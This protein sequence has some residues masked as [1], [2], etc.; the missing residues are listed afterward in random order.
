MSLS[1]KKEPEFV[2]AITATDLET[3]V[4]YADEDGQVYVLAMDDKNGERRVVC[5]GNYNQPFIMEGEMQ[6]FE[7]NRILVKGTVFELTSCIHEGG[8]K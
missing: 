1:I 4:W 3:G 6:D 7:V 8:V 5:L 2:S